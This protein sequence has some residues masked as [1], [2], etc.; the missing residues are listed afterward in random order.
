M[1]HTNGASGPDH[2]IQHHAPLGSG[3]RRTLEVNA[4]DHTTSTLV[5]FRGSLGSSSQCTAT[6]CYVCFITV[7]TE[8]VQESKVANRAGPEARH[9]Q[10]SKTLMS[11][12]KLIP[13]N[14]NSAVR[15]CLAAMTDSRCESYYRLT[16]CRVHPYSNYQMDTLRGGRQE[17]GPP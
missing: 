3:A 10:S 8:T 2:L 13:R 6:Y 9:P 4:V 16:R 11:S 17:A 5:L 1:A 14:M 7:L 15:Q 12:C